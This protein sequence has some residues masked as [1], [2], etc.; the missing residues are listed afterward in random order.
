MKDIDAILSIKT[1]MA[2]WIV[3][4]CFLTAGAVQR[5][6][7]VTA[8][9]FNGLKVDCYGRCCPQNG[10]I[11][12]IDII[13]K[14]KFYLSFENGYHCV[15]YITEKL[16]H[17]GYEMNTVPIV[18]GA[19]K[20]D[21]LGVVPPHSCIFVED[22]KTPKHLVNYLNYLDKND[23]AYKEYFMWRTKQVSEM[24]QYGRKTGTCQICR[25]LHG[26]NIDNT[27]NPYYNTLKTDI[28]NYGYTYKPR[29]VKSLGGWFY[30]TENPEC[31]NKNSTDKDLEGYLRTFGLNLSFV[32]GR[33]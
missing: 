7:L 13:K 20:S 1:H 16:Y 28:P 2:I 26:I 33:P 11:T 32:S 15:D 29:I 19:K 27:F 22:F 9:R 25:I 5:M 6:H 12:N 23:T 18:W 4:N 14:Y 17:N 30:G 31:F 10:P 8:L 3:S 21:Y 24:P